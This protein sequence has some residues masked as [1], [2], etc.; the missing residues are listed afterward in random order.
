M[1]N[2]RLVMFPHF[3]ILLPQV[4]C[5]SNYQNSLMDCKVLHKIS[6]ASPSKFYFLAAV[7][8]TLQ[9]SGY[10][11]CFIDSRFESWH[12]LVNVTV[13]CHFPQS[14]HAHY[15]LYCGGGFA[16]L[17]V[18]R[19]HSIRCLDDAVSIAMGYRMDS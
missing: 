3:L 12:R 9:S 10:D 13:S 8:Q 16:I 15:T 14:T 4:V 11:S 6:K 7:N 2:I 18:H 5:F 17:S 19:L 1:I